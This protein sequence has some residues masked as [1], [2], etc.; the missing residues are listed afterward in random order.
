MKSTLRIKQEEQFLKSNHENYGID[1]LNEPSI[2]D[3]QDPVRVFNSTIVLVQ[4]L[5]QYELFN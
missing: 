1:T 5:T 2:Y 4:A 3:F